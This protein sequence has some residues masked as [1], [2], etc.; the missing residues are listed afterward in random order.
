[1]NIEEIVKDPQTWMIPIASVITYILTRGKNR[2]DIRKINAD[3]ENAIID[4]R[5]KE[6]KYEAEKYEKLLKRVIESELMIEDLSLQIQEL[7]QKLINALNINKEIMAELT[8]Y[9][10]IK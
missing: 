9:R 10:T 4:V 2:A 8:I 7:S 5:V 6:D 1:M 3:A